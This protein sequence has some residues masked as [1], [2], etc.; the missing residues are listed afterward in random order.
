ML[1]LSD[2]TEKSGAEAEGRYKVKTDPETAIMIA[3]RFLQSEH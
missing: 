2:F 1:S 3:I